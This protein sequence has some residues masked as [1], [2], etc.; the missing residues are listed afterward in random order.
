MITPNFFNSGCEELLNRVLEAVKPKVHVFG[1]VH[2]GELSISLN[3]HN[4]LSQ[5]TVNTWAVVQPL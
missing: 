1:H 2:E 5:A 4:F 3:V